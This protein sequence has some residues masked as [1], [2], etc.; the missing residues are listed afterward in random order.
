MADAVAQKRAMSKEVVIDDG[1]GTE[2]E[3]ALILEAIETPLEK[4][5][6]LAF[7]LYGG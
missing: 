6:N 7:I 2:S 1:T 4:R 3:D 5:R